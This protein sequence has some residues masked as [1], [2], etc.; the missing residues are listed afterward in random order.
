M[1]KEQGISKYKLNKI[2]TESL[3]NTIRLHFDSILLYENGSYPSALQLSVLALE[4]FS[5]AIW[6][7]HYIWTSETNEGYPGA[8]FE[9]EWLKLLYLHPKKQW[10]FVAKETYDYSPNFISLIRN[11][12]LEEKKQ[13]AIYVG[14]S[15]AKGR[16]DVSSRV[17]TPW[18]IKQKDARQFISIINDELLRIYA[19]IEDDE[20]YFEGGNDMDDVFDY[21]IYKKLF[22]WPHKSGIKNN[23]WRKKNLQRS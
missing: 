18:R 13:N 14:L 8:E 11:R 17:S 6:V 2:A 21:D 23:G 1:K 16:I 15:R 9:Q 22:K 19:R 7:D 4:E 5:K 20:F 12:K 10:N 3:R